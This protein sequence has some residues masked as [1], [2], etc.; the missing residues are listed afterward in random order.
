MS[1]SAPVEM[2]VV[3]PTWNNCGRLGL[4]LRALRACA[5][6]DGLRWELVVV[7]NNCTDA[8][9]AVVAALAPTLPELV[10]LHEPRPGVSRARNAGVRR[11]MGSLLVLTDDDVTPCHGWLA[12]YTVAARARPTGFYFGGPVE[13]EFE[14]AACDRELVR[15]GPPSV[16]G[17]DLGGAERA[18][19]AGE[20]FIGA[21][22]A[23]PRQAVLDVGGYDE[24]LGLD[25]SR[26]EVRGGGETDLM[27]R[28]NAA[29][30]TPWYLPEARIAHFVPSRKS[31]LRHIAERAESYARR[32]AEADSGPVRGPLGIP[33]SMYPRT[34]ELWVAWALARLRG[35]PAYHEYLELRR[36]IGRMRG[37]ARRRKRLARA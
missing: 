35:R 20:Y 14:T 5:V 2:S 19:T 32:I 13:S 21:N 9:D 24:G 17:L 15:L 6:P 25:P 4:T 16:K 28:L 23:C 18:L 36:A 37:L 29:G 34:A 10:Y 33:P 8:T 12:A 11:A 7:N 22:W 26:G 27:A 30:W 1:G 31:T 3:L